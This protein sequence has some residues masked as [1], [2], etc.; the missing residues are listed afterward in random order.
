PRTGIRS[1]TVDRPALDGGCERLRGHLL[2]D[3]EVAQA[4]GQGHDHPGPLLAVD[5]G[6]HLVG[7]SHRN[8]RSSTR[9]L[10][11]LEPR[12]ASRSAL[13]EARPPAKTQWPLASSSSLKASI[14][15]ISSAVAELVVSSSTV[16]RYCAIG[17]ISCRRW[18]S[19]GP[20]FTP[21]TNAAASIRHTP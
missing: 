18:P 15:A 17:I 5:P 20:P 3:V 13:G 12:A 10:Q 11:A 7:V 2:G 4:P 14:A 21:A 16:I 9:R 19:L 8:G 6:D 1:D